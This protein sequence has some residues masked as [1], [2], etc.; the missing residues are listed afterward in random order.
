MGREILPSNG[1]KHLSYILSVV[2]KDAAIVLTT[3][4]LGI[5]LGNIS[6]TLAPKSVVLVCL[7]IVVRPLSKRARVGI[8][9]ESA[10]S[11]GEG[12]DIKSLVDDESD[13]ILNLSDRPEFLI[14]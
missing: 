10:V 14:I 7:L 1:V 9:S 13:A 2:D 4:K 8:K 6:G 12:E 5:P 3:H 11:L